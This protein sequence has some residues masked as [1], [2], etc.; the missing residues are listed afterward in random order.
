MRLKKEQLSCIMLA[1]EIESLRESLTD[2]DKI[3]K[4]LRLSNELL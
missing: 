2:K 3:I 4:K 1:K